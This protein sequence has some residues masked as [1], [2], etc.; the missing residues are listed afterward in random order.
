MA[1]I[2]TICENC[3]VIFENP[4][5]DIADN[6]TVQISGISFVVHC[7]N[8]GEQVVTSP[9]GFY[10]SVKGVIQFLGKSDRSI[11][12]LKSLARLLDDAR[13]KQQSATEVSQIIQRELPKLSPVA[14]FLT[15]HAVTLGLLVGFIG[16]LLTSIQTIVT[17]KQYQESHQQK[18]N[19][20]PQQV[21]NQTF[22]QTFV[23][24]TPNNQDKRKLQSKKPVINKRGK[25]NAPCSCGSWRKYK[26][27]HG[28]QGN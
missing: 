28:A 1:K 3:G 4:A 2:P 14:S 20:D 15:K 22:N 23:Y 12:E 24:T 17:I 25:V 9:E 6:A 10:K 19:I 7:P 26:K 8:C 13:D 5:L 21:I 18:P 27:C 16:L 11:S